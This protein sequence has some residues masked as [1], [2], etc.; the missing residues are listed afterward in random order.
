[1]KVII[2]KKLYLFLVT[3]LMIP[4]AAFSQGEYLEKRQSGLGFTAGFSTNKDANAIGAGIGYSFNGIF[5]IGFSFARS[6]SEGRPEESASNISPSVNICLF[7]QNK[8]LPISISMGAS[9]VKGSYSSDILDKYDLEM[10]SS[11]F[12]VGSKIFGKVKVF[13][14]LFVMPLF[15]ISYYSLTLKLEDEDGNSEKDDDS[16]IQINLG[17][18]IIF[19]MKNINLKNLLIISPGIS[20]NEDY[21]TFFVDLTFVLPD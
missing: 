12:V 19:D 2:M 14:N 5:D 9:Y 3:I 10:S 7:K 13:K 4:F 1:M 21:N 20:I 8:Y 11:G 6:T 15:G 18:P 17:L 16:T